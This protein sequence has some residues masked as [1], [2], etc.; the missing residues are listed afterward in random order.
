MT[1]VECVEA[2]QEGIWPLIQGRETP[3]LIRGALQFFHWPARRWSELAALRVEHGH[4]RVGVRFAS[5][6]SKRTLW[7]GECHQVDVSLNDFCA[8]LTSDLSDSHPLLAFPTHEWWGYCAYQHFEELFADLAES[9]C[10]SADFAQLLGSSVP[11]TSSAPTLWLGSR[12]AHTPCH[13][14]AYGINLVAQVSG[15]K[16]WMLFPPS[17]GKFLSPQRLPFEDASTFTRHDPIINGAPEGSNAVVAVLKTDD[18]LYVP[19]H[20]YHAVE[21]MSPHSLS[22]NQW[23]DC[24][25][26]GVERIKEALVRCAVSPHLVGAPESWWTNPGEVV[27]SMSENLEQLA[28]AA[29]EGLRLPE[30]SEDA[31]HSAFVKAITHP[32]V[33]ASVAHL[34]VAELQ[35]GNLAN[36]APTENK[37]QFCQSPMSEKK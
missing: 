15:V 24:S 32:D 22:L 14:D 30:P 33:I 6:T 34:F 8:W 10:H 29:A 27:C 3:L 25:D 23:F 1:D 26:D 19:R 28:V 31:I 21:C 37:P 12:G 4:R 20:W 17:D 35:R 36:D 13:L 2:S 18:V 11:S 7:E 9:N 5:L 16:R